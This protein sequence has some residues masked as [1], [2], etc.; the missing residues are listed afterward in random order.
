MISEKRAFT[1]LAVLAVAVAA[2]ALVLTACDR[3][4]MTE[5]PNANLASSPALKDT[6]PLGPE[7]A[8]EKAPGATG[9]STLAAQVKSAIVA[10][11]ALKTL[12]VEVNATDGVVT[13]FGTADTQDK[14]HQAAIVALNVEGVRSVRN[15]MIVLRGS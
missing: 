8:A 1:R 5:S 15:E 12:T 2:A 7:V 10:E 11:P 3:K 4:P 13:L 6:Q 14:R 9:D